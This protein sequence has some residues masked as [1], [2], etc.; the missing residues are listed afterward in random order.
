MKT[1]LCHSA[2]IAGKVAESAA[3]KA[4]YSL[5]PRRQLKVE[6]QRTDIELIKLVNCSKEYDILDHLE[7][8]QRRRAITAALRA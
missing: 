1:S 8:V 4:V 7:L 6:L 3:I 5:L 2:R